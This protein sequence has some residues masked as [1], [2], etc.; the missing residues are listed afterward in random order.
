MPDHNIFT[1]QLTNDGSFTFFSQ[2]FGEAFHSIYGAK[3]EARLSLL[4]LA[5]SPKKRKNLSS[6][7][8]MFVMD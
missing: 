2:E 7:C 4:N 5:K 8:W 1:P 3:E 6:I